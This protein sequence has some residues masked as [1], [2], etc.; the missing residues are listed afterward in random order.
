MQKF[1]IQTPTGAIEID[2]SCE[3]TA[4]LDAQD[5]GLTVL[6]ANAVEVSHA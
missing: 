3:E 5:Q 4:I 2:A 1:Q 6:S